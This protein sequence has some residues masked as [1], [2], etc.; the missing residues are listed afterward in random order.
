MPLEGEQ[1]H[2]SLTTNADIAGSSARKGQVPD[3]SR[4]TKDKKKTVPEIGDKI[5]LSAFDL[6]PEIELP[7]EYQEPVSHPGPVKELGILTLRESLHE[8]IPQH[9]GQHGILYYDFSDLPKYL[10]RV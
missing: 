10:V 4:N 1:L 6:G 7:P 3:E 8:F 5:Q 9:P 2:D